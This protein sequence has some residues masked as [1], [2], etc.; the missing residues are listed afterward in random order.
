[1]F[2]LSLLQIPSDNSRGSSIDSDWAICFQARVRRLWLISYVN[3]R[4][5]ENI[6]GGEEELYDACFH[7]AGKK[8]RLTNEQVQF[9]E[10]KLGHFRNF[11]RVNSEHNAFS[12]GLN[13]FAIGRALSHTP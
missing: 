3:D 7:Q 8:R 12:S 1:M 6:S 9:L 4:L 13:D 10:L 11:Q 5:F 2:P